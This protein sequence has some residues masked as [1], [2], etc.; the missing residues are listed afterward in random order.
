MI[1]LVSNLIIPVFVLGVILY[2]VFKKVD[3]YDTFVDGAKESFDMAL[4]MFPSLLAMIVGVNVFMK[5]G[6]IEFV[7]QLLKPVFEFSFRSISDGS[8]ATN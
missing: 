3:V 2:G 1:Q 5:S 4:T 6:A 8:D 7:F